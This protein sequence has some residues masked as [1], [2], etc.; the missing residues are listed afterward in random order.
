MDSIQLYDT[1][2]GKIHQAIREIEGVLV[3]ICMQIE[4]LPVLVQNL[5]GTVPIGYMLNSIDINVLGRKHTSR[6]KGLVYKMLE[7][8]LI[9]F[10]KYIRIS[11]VIDIF[12]HNR[13]LVPGILS[14]NEILR[15]LKIQSKYTVSETSTPQLKEHKIF[16]DGKLF[17]C[18]QVYQQEKENE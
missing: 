3:N 9:E 15:R 5:T 1:A 12:S 2:E 17:H 11:I 8:E 4:E 13:Y 16:K 7:R 18:G 6:L 14:V 10:P